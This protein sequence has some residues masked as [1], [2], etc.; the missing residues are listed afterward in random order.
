MPHR[1]LTTITFWA[2]NVLLLRPFG[3]ALGDSNSAPNLRL[4]LLGFPQRMVLSL[5]SSELPL[6]N[7]TTHQASDPQAANKD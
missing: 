7:L 5:S 1:V 4:S 3:Y 6:V 2:L